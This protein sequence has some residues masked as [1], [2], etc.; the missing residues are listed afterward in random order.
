MA[1]WSRIQHQVDG[2]IAMAVVAA[3]SDQR[4]WYWRE[5]LRKAIQDFRETQTPRVSA[6]QLF[7]GVD[8]IDIEA[9]AVRLFG[10]VVDNSQAAVDNYVVLYNTATPVEGTTGP[11]VHVWAPRAAVTCHVFPTPV[12]F[13]TAL[14]WSALAGTQAAIEAGT[15]AAASVVR[16]A[17]VYLE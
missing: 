2:L 13:D 10:V 17:M 5:G 11:L 14:S 1:E 4:L 16:A 7:D 9:N 3:R 12:V 6:Y 8:D 15:L